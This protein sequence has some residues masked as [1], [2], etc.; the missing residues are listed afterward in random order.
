MPPRPPV[1]GAV[2]PEGGERRESLY[3]YLSEGF[4]FRYMHEAVVNLVWADLF[5][6]RLVIV[7]QFFF[8]L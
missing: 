5:G 8:V 7:E 2:G 6:V 1:G 4:L 3:G